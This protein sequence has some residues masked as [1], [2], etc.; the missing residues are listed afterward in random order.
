MHNDK[1]FYLIK[2]ASSTLL[3]DRAMILFKYV[4]FFFFLSIVELSNSSSSHATHT[5]NERT[6]E[7]IPH[8]FVCVKDIHHQQLHVVGSRTSLITV[9]IFF[10]NTV[11]GERKRQQSPIDVVSVNIYL[12]SSH[13]VLAAN[14]NTLYASHN[15]FL[16]NSQHNTT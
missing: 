15:S 7:E 10:L 3:F 16:H 4:V 6:N 5:T 1:K 9:F 2:S 13:T 11:Q 8:S 12:I 14:S